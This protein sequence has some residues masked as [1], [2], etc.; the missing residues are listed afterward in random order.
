MMF[1]NSKTGSQLHTRKNG[2]WDWQGLSHE[3]L[4]KYF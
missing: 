2:K 1:E 3:H 4:E